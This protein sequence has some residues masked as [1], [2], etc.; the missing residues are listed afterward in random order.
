[1]ISYMRLCVLCKNPYLH[2]LSAAFPL[3]IR[4]G[5]IHHYIYRCTLINYRCV[6]FW[7]EKCSVLW[8]ADDIAVDVKVAA[9]AV[10]NVVKP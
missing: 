3:L 6:L 2:T 7:Y 4:Q 10:F 8:D 5:R 1:M 9:V